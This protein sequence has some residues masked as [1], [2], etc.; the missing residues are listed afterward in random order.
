VAVITGASRRAGIGYGLAR[1]L[2]MMGA[3]LYLQGWRAHDAEW[4]WGEDPDDAETLVR[5]I[6]RETGSR[7]EYVE[8][9]FTDP[10]APETVMQGAVD[11]FGH[12]D[13]LVANHTR[14]SQS[15]IGTLT[16]EEIDAQMSVDVRATMLLMQAFA[17]QHDGRPGG[18]VVLFTSGQH[19]GPMPDEL[20]YAVAKG[21]VHQMT[22]SFAHALIRRGIVLNTVNPGPTDNGAYPR[23]IIEDTSP[24]P[25]GRWGQPEDI[26]RLVGWLCTD[27]AQWVVGQVINSEGGFRM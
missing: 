25:Q 24:F 21:A 5:D 8:A 7:A 15:D 6:R 3:D 11:A 17:L 27:E 16:A 23:E 19:L 4:P 9:N 10:H 18:R 12:A 1:N 20:P 13:I 26:A 14:A 22:L 2:G